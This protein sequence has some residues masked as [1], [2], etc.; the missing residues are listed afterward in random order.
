LPV[1]RRRAG[2]AHPAHGRRPRTGGWRRLPAGVLAAVLGASVAAGV[3]GTV[4]TLARGRVGAAPPD[5]ERLAVTE[6][7][8]RAALWL[9]AHAA[10]D[11]VVATNVHCRP[12][13]TREH[14]DA[15]AFWVAGLG[16]HRTVVESWGYTDQAV[17]A[18]ARDGRSYPRQPAPD[19]QR[20]ALNER[21]FTAPTAADL[22]ILRQRYGVRWLFADDRAGPVSPELGRLATLRLVSGSVRIYELTGG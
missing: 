19:A 15:R 10:D 9:D 5:R 2:P 16:G 12:V 8:M 21:A 18:H 1:G 4:Q 22:R 20:F 14:C 6:A 13:P 11:D 7:E 3:V 17:A